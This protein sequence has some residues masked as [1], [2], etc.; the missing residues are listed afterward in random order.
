[1]ALSSSTAKLVSC[2]P[3]SESGRLG[4]K[5]FKRT[6]RILVIARWLLPKKLGEIP[7]RQRWAE[8]EK[9]LQAGRSKRMCQAQGLE[10]GGAI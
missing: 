6:Q 8:L 7:K 2:C 9:P 4:A 5:L 1:V 3:R 10:E